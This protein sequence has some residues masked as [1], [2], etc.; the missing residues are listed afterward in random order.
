MA[1]SDRSSARPGRRGALAAI[2]AAIPILSAEVA[3]AFSPRERI[4]ERI[5][6]EF[7]QGPRLRREGAYMALTRVPVW[8]DAQRAPG[9]DFDATPQT[10]LIGEDEL[11][12]VWKQI[13][14]LDLRAYDQLPAAA[15]VALPPDAAGPER[16]RVTVGGQV[17]V[18]LLRESHALA[19]R[20]RAPLLA[21]ARDLDALF[22]RRRDQPLAPRDLV[23][24]VERTTTTEHDWAR[25]VRTVGG[26][27]AECGAV[28]AGAPAAAAPLGQDAFAAL[29]KWILDARILDRT[30]SPTAPGVPGAPPGGPPPAGTQPPA[31]HGYT[32]ELRVEGYALA[33]RQAAGEFAGRLL[34][35]EL[36]ARLQ[37]LS[38][39]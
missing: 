26:T 16:L 24:R 1:S 18:D 10:V 27:R 20:W 25:L 37:S 7:S 29:W 36:L 2:A 5:D 3:M 15:F 34:L 35:D 4:P 39:P 8:S 11:S 14:A 6:W 19:Q 33:V 30:F 32:V 21:I 28:A 12:A 17:E 22:E 23:L 9:P 38:R 31:R 13:A